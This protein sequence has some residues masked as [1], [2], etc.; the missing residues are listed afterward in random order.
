MVVSL[1]TLRADH[2]HCYGY[3]RET[4]PRLDEFAAESVLFEETIAESS[5]TLPTHVTMF[6]GL[7]QNVHGV[8]FGRHRLAAEAVTL[9]EALRS[10]G[11]RTK[12]V[13]SGPFLHGFFGLDQG[14]EPGDY[15]GYV[16]ETCYDDASLDVT[17]ESALAKIKATHD[18]SHRTVTSAQI[19]DDGIRF[20]DEVRE[21][22]AAG[23]DTRPFFLFLHYF[24]IH[25]DYI[26]PEKDAAPFLADLPPGGND[27]E[28]KRNE[29]IARYDGEI[30][31]TDRHLGRF[32]DALKASG[33]DENTIVL[34]TSDHGEE[35]LDH[36]KYGHNATL[37]DEVL[38]VPLLIRAP[39]AVRGLRVR[40]PARHADI[41]PTILDLAGV[42]VP[43]PITGES[44]APV[45][46]G[47]EMAKE[48][49]AVARL[50]LG[51]NHDLVAIRHRGKKFIRRRRPEG[52]DIELFDLVRDGQERSPLTGEEAKR[53]T[54]RF[55]ERLQAIEAY[56][57]GVAARLSLGDEADADIPPHLKKA[58]EELGYLDG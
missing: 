52:V 1:D 35:F 11:Y 7:S 20:L 56:E 6:T 34:I 43:S 33:L 57:V 26:P 30:R 58:L 12:G 48:R 24:D 3:S 28:A 17:D 8:G 5:W 51:A 21:G 50:R 37:Y 18:E 13:W 36:G 45:V 32:L 39:D 54:E 47:A 42:P 55:E 40:A 22:R 10:A 46:R 53:F 27:V 4:S 16:G 31:F 15:Y 2:L 9:A 44:L 38:R 29:T 14:F 41:M 49:A 25:A 19:S 23:A